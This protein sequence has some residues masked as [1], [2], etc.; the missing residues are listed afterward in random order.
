MATENKMTKKQTLVVEQCTE[1]LSKIFSNMSLEE[2][3]ASIPELKAAFG[4][5][6]RT[7]HPKIKEARELCE[8]LQAYQKANKPKKQKVEKKAPIKIRDLTEKGEIVKN[9]R[10]LPHFIKDG[11]WVEETGDTE[12]AWVGKS[13][14]NKK[15]K[16]QKNKKQKKQKPS[17]FFVN[18]FYG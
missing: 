14:K 12:D 16:K 13:K 7:T 15:T 5:F 3:V 4:R 18:G 1:I 9:F 2:K 10:E 6:R 11:R 17:G 8:E